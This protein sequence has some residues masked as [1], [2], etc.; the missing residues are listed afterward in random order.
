[1]SDSARGSGDDAVYA[2]RARRVVAG[3]CGGEAVVLF[4]FCGF[5]LWQLTQGGGD[6][7]GRVIVSVVLIVVFALALLVLA[8]FWRR[9]AQWP[10]TPTAL[11]NGLLLPVAWGLVQGGRGWLAAAVGIVAVTGIVAALGA[12]DD[13]QESP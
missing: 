3:V 2:A 11:W 6:D 8:Q 13:A 10:V 1:M 12:R 9:G 4:G 7:A 5:Y